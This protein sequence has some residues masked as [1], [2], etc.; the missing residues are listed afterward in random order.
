VEG[1]DHVQ[2]GGGRGGANNAHEDAQLSVWGPAPKHQL[3]NVGGKE[4]NNNMN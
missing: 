3:F 4:M 1:A 2:G